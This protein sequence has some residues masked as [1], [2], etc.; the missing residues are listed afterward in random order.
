MGVPG[1]AAVQQLRRQ[2]VRPKADLL[3]KSRSSTIHRS[4]PHIDARGCSIG[5]ST[6]GG[7]RGRQQKGD[8]AP[9]SAMAGE[10]DIGDEWDT[11]RGPKAR[12][13][14]S[15]ARPAPAPGLRAGVVSPARQRV[16]STVAPRAPY[17]SARH[18]L[19]ED[20]GIDRLHAEALG[21]ASPAQH[22]QIR[23]RQLS[24]QM[25]SQPLQRLA[26]LERGLTA[27][28]P[29][30]Q[31]YPSQ[32]PD[33]AGSAAADPG[34]ASQEGPKAC[35]RA[36]LPSW[37][38]AG[39]PHTPNNIDNVAEGTVSDRLLDSSNPDRP[40]M[41]NTCATDRSLCAAQVCDMAHNPSL[42]SYGSPEELP[43]ELLWSSP[44]GVTAAAAERR[45]V[46]SAA[47]GV[48]TPPSRRQ[49]VPSGV[50]HRPPLRQGSSTLRGGGGGGVWP[51]DQK[52][53]RWPDLGDGSV[54][55]GAE[56]ALPALLER[57]GDAAGPSAAS[58]TVA[59]GRMAAGS[60]SG[61]GGAGVEDDEAM[62]LMLG[63]SSLPT[64]LVGSR[65]VQD[66]ADEPT[67]TFMSLSAPDPT[68]SVFQQQ[69]SLEA[70]AGGS[71]G[72]VAEAAGA[73]AS[74]GTT[75]SVVA[76]SGLRIARAAGPPTGPGAGRRAPHRLLVLGSKAT[77]SGAAA[78]LHTDWGMESALE[79][80]AGVG[81]AAS[82]ASAGGAWAMVTSALA[83][84]AWG[85]APVGPAAELGGGGGTA[86]GGGRPNSFNASLLELTPAEQLEAAAVLATA[87]TGSCSNGEAAG[88]AAGPGSGPLEAGV[89][90]PSAPAPRLQSVHLASGRT[91]TMMQQAAGQ[92]GVAHSAIGAAPALPA[93]G[94]AVAA[95]SGN[96]AS[97]DALL[98]L[99]QD[100]WSAG[101]AWTADAVNIFPFAVV[102]PSRPLATVRFSI[103]GLPPALLTAAVT[104]ARNSSSV[105]AAVV[106]AGPRSMDASAG[107]QRPAFASAAGSAGGGGGTLGTSVGDSEFS[108]RGALPSSASGACCALEIAVR[109]AGRYL[110]VQWTVQLGLPGV[111][112]ASSSSSRPIG[113][114]GW[115]LGAGGGGAGDSVE[116]PFHPESQRGNTRGDAAGSGPGAMSGSR[117]GAGASAG[118]ASAAGYAV[119]VSV[120]GVNGPGLLSVEVSW[121]LVQAAPWLSSSRWYGLADGLV[122]GVQRWLYGL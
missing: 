79:N 36:P 19:D 91:I 80:A 5:G 38:L 42:C 122:A 13:T 73:A 20:Q 47:D 119:D 88:A 33:A 121:V 61:A 89:A 66:C 72:T 21:P 45:C 9:S 58:R 55:G 117:S 103:H 30:S 54:H 92:T 98:G 107:L 28:G 50:V 2:Y 87:I 8:N 14:A 115:K 37:P 4:A 41:V 99:S 7:Q 104:M 23:T 84:G 97:T 76:A 35:V 113:S 112:G 108:R 62:L 71:M 18:A 11:A 109:C 101:S 12:D 32:R 29:S 48:M 90:R 100:P 52:W 106:A 63:P 95:A 46:W 78:W 40:W 25:T 60:G 96:A 24:P 10:D 114:Q 16:S 6:A 110:P 26:P 15:A 111:A 102:P 86:S 70:D 17:R 3:R 51:R 82:A 94:P 69:L 56:D 39:T 75:S 116:S 85:C 27:P 118:A 67:L 53:E 34:G 49:R 1:N 68:D 59:F 81:R 93:T 57:R 77:S 44:R 120:T 64:G 74:L 83:D 65:D 22:G 43:F 105:T 31:L